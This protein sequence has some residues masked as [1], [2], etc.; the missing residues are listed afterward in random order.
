MDPQHLQ[1]FIDSAESYIPAVRGGILLAA[2]DGRST[3]E[4]ETSVKHLRTIKGAAGLIGL[5][6]VSRL[7]E[8]LVGELCERIAGGGTLSERAANEYLD[9]LAALEEEISGRQEFDIDASEF[10]EESFANLII[11]DARP[12]EK[13]AAEPEP[14]ENRTAD[15]AEPLNEASADADSW[16]E[17]EFEIDEEM[18]EIFAMEAED[19]LQNINRNLEL[20]EKNPNDR[21][22][23]L[24]IRRSSHTLKGSAG[25]VGLK[26]LSKL[27]HKVEDLLDFIS[28]NDIESN[29][30][31]FQL[32]LT[33][34]DCISAVAGNDNPPDLPGKIR[35]T[36]ERFDELLAALAVPGPAADADP[37]PAPGP[38][39]DPEKKTSESGTEPGFS[40]AA[41]NAPSA[42]NPVIRVSLDKLDDLVKLVGEMIF[43][44]SVFE[45]R[46]SEFEQQIDEFQNSTR[47]LRH[48]TGKLET[49]FEAGLLGGLTANGGARRPA[50]PAAPEFDSLEFDRYNEFSQTTRELIETTND[51][52]TI[53]TE[54]EAVHNYLTLLFD[55]QKRLIDEMQEKLLS[56]RM[57]SF[58]SLATRLQRTVRVTAEEEDK[59]VELSIEGENLEVDTQIL[60][61]LID[62][63][64]H[65]LRNAVAHGIETP[66]TRRLLGKEEKGRISL[67]VRSEG[68]HIV[69]TIADDGRGISPGALREKALAAGLL[70]AERGAGM[71]D[72]EALDLVFLAGLT[73][74]EE[75]SQVAG[76]GVGMNIVKTNIERQNGTISIASEQ[77]LGTTFTIRLPM[78][79]AVTRCLIVRA[80]DHRFA[81]PLKLVGRISEIAPNNLRRARTQ[82]RLRIGDVGYRIAHLNELLG[83]PVEESLSPEDVPLLLLDT[84]K[85]PCALIVDRI[86]K[87]Q[88][89]VIKPLGRPLR[90]LKSLLGATLL[91]DG[92]V[93]PVLDLIHL[94]DEHDPA[95]AKHASP[96]TPPRAA[97]ERVT[98][99]IVDD[100]PSVRH[101]NSKLV[102]NNNWEPLVARDGAEAFELLNASND[103]PD[104]ILTDVE[105]PEMDGYE[106]LAAIRQTERL[107]GI[108]VIMLTSRTSEKHRGKA[109]ELGVSDY[110]TKPYDDARL[111]DS[112]R[113]LSG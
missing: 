24:E 106:L 84:V 65:L 39:P 44:R 11:A 86:V 25:I 62:P 91:G 93:V 59:L 47:R 80:G 72:E 54:L 30:E 40:A 90:E 61:A 10:V 52:S 77:Q 49:S 107:R 43:S 89:V 92:S 32:L 26:T 85:K 96:A 12:A 100:S 99:M 3:A 112:I 68:T 104:V 50:D 35:R 111:I 19:H 79:L 6:R 42:A 46:L 109:Y 70:P 105:M 78:A 33:A 37:P 38:A 71:T 57:I 51:T 75:I 22:A 58:G 87:P 73:T 2:R 55:N 41:R 17:E 69:L 76:R 15:P 1:A 102:R 16:D 7:A 27:A 67:R 108:P 94:L 21:E 9:R 88:E 53:N 45:Q 34:T 31:I 48:S 82:G 13:R 74:A 95:A 5:D 81:F 63:L 56:L 29:E 64:L 18:L 8:E 66:E 4:L 103:L 28:D 60:D 14:V 113:K 101:V 23:L 98:V 110:I 83:L 36:E 20:L 97:K